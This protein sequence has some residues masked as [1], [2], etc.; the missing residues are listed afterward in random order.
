MDLGWRSDYAT[1]HPILDRDHKLLL[2]TIATL[3]DGWCDHG[4]INDILRMLERY[5]IAHFEREETIMRLTQYPD[6]AAHQAQ[7]EGF[8]ATVARLRARWASHDDGGIKAEI[9]QELSQWLQ[10]HILD[11]DRRIADWVRGV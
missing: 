3:F 1:G 4:T 8:R 5:V 7:H 2:D 11:S 6:Q 10:G 9:A